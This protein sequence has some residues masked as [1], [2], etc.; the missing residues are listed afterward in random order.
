MNMLDFYWTSTAGVCTLARWTLACPVCQLLAEAH[1]IAYQCSMSFWQLQDLIFTLF[2]CKI[3]LWVF[4]SGQKWAMS[5]RSCTADLVFQY[6]LTQCAIMST[7]D[8]TGLGKWAF[9]FWRHA[10]CS[11]AF[12]AVASQ[13]FSLSHQSIWS[14]F[15]VRIVVAVWQDTL[16]VRRIWKWKI[17]SKSITL[18]VAWLFEAWLFEGNHT[19]NL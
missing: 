9:G 11:K 15:G 19:Y 1:A 4:G 13:V 18:I 2:V 17:R 16:A 3:S 8:I 7:Y 6:I 12:K 14:W 10:S 5:L